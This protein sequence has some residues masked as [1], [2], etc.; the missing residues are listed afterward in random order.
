MSTQD[1]LR[2]TFR[3]NRVTWTSSVDVLNRIPKIIAQ[4]RYFHNL[5]TT[6]EQMELIRQSLLEQEQE[7]WQF[8]TTLFEGK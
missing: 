2:D 8:S 5:Q 4:Y 3:E 1:H 7:S 6:K